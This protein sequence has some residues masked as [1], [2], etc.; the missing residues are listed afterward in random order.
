MSRDP[1]H[2]LDKD[3]LLARVRPAG[4][5][6]LLAFWDSL[7]ETQRQRLS[8]QIA[9]LDLKL[10]ARLRG[11]KSE[12]A[13]GGKAH[14]AAL[15]AGA[16][17]PPAIRTS[18]QG[19]FT[20]QQA[21]DRGSQALRAGEVGMILVAGGLGTRLGFD[22]PKGMFEI[23][24][25]S[26]RCLFAVLIDNLRAVARRYDVSIPLYLMTSPA[27]DAATRDFFRDQ[28]NLGL[29]AGELRFFCQATMWALDDRGEKILLAEPDS[30]F[31]GPDGHGGMLQA[32]AESGCLADVRARGIK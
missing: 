1:H 11:R 22:Q 2:Q 15:A 7:D 20:R 26:R 8:G 4:Q 29:T 28:G 3:A 23:G 19:P 12:S 30:L 5:E 31:L 21:I 16:A 14:F 10:L 18:G 9:Q 13:E 32:L 17:S 27:T 6:H 24:P 25:L